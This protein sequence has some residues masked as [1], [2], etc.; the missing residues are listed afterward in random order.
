MDER[1]AHIKE[2]DS[3]IKDYQ[4]EIRD[5][6]N[7]EAELKG[8]YQVA[9]GSQEEADLDLLKKASTAEGRSMLTGKCIHNLL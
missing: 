2:I 4:S 3:E 9:D 5:L 6:Q 1:R 7:K 8:R